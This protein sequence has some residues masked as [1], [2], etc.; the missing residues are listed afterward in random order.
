MLAVGD[1]AGNVRLLFRNGTQRA[2]VTAGGAVH[3]M[4]RGGTNNAHLAV[5]AA[6]VGVVLLDMGK[7]T[8]P[9]M[10]C[11]GSAPSSTALAVV[12]SSSKKG[13]KGSSA[14]SV[15]PPHVVSLAWDVQ[16][17]QL[18]YAASSDGVI[19][20][21]NS[22]TRTR[23][24][25]GEFKNISKM[26][27]H[28]KLVTTIQGH[29]AAPVALTPVKGYLYSAS[30]SLFVSHNVSGASPSLAPRAKPPA[31]QDCRA[32]RTLGRDRMA[33]P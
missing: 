26:V 19:A 29:D 13:A 15:A 21:Y 6:G 10:A 20:I 33:P 25:T 28:C 3:A 31:T 1:A 27:T 11:E 2:A 4:E 9:P 14:A 18:L 32:A 17:P 22:K 12:S 8:T 30:P 5:G 7:P 23:Q 16:L 24:M